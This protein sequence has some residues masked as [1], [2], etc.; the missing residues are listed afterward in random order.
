MRGENQPMQLNHKMLGGGDAASGAPI[1]ILHGL[2]GL[3]DNWLGIAKALSLTNPVHLLDLRN[4]GRSPHNPVFN[5]AAMGDDLDEFMQG[6][7]LNG[8]VLIGHSMGGKVAMHYACLH[9]D[10]LNR[11]VV[12]DIAPRYYPVHHRVILDALLGVDLAALQNRQQAD[13]QLARHIAETDVRQFLLKNLYRTDGGTFAW[14]F[15]LATIN[16]QIENVGEVLPNGFVFHKPTQFIRGELSHYIKD[17]D[18]ELILRQFPEARL[19]TVA[20]AGHW[21]HAEKPA[22]L[23]ALLR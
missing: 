10:R 16:G 2:F 18:M 14:R 9:P 4:H 3:A 6:Q 15:D 1:V 23:L 5:Y 11:L 13:E 22:E 21:V 19:E 8:A 7:D 17:A 20:G 12:I